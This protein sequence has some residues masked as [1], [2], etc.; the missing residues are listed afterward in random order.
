ME[1]RVVDRK[2]LLIE[3]RVVVSL[4]SFLQLNTVRCVR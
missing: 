2:L 4:E 3:G 1:G